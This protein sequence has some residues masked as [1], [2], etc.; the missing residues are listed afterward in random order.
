MVEDSENKELIVVDRDNELKKWEHSR[1]V[2][3]VKTY[4]QMLKDVGKENF[5]SCWTLYCFY[6]ATGRRQ[7]T[8]QPYALDTYCMAGLNW[9]RTT[10]YKYKKL[11]L[12]HGYID[13]IKRR[14]YG[15]KFKKGEKITFIKVNFMSNG[16]TDSTTF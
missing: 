2:V 6:Y 13:Q 12:E 7:K 3:H 9:C 10:F 1:I 15:G 14:S 8:N 4:W 5:E 16:I 11:L